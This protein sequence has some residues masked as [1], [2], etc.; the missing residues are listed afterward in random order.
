MYEV[1]FKFRNEYGEL[2]ED[3][4]DNNGLGFDYSE[5]QDLAEE[6]RFRGHIDVKVIMLH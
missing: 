5:A 6:L 2:V 1:I 3:Y 4:L